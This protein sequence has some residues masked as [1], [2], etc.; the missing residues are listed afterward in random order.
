MSPGVCS[1]V[2]LE[3]E[4]EGAEDASGEGASIPGGSFRES[5]GVGGGTP[6]VGAVIIML[7]RITMRR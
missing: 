3:T 6:S 2:H 1:E 7:A 4:E 5:A